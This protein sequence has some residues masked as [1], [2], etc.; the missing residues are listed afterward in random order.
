MFIIFFFLFTFFIFAQ[1]EENNY[2]TYPLINPKNIQ[3]PFETY[4]LDNLENYENSIFNPLN[5]EI[6]Q[7]KIEQIKKDFFNNEKKE[8]KKKVDK[9]PYKETSFR[10][11]NIIFFMTLPFTTVFSYFVGYQF[12]VSKKTEG[13]LMIFTSSVSLS[14]LNVY[15]DKKSLNSNLNP[16]F[17]SLDNTQSLFFNL[18]SKN[19]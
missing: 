14:F 3:I 17:H 5:G 8:A 13:A 15:Y 19:F 7:K 18:A 4:N 10:R 12:G 16:H 6:N 11:S 9:T 2:R 1:E